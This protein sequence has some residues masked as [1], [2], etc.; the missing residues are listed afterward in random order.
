V[1]LAA[2]LLRDLATGTTGVALLWP[3]T[4]RP[5]SIR[6]RTYVALLV[7]LAGYAAGGEPPAPA[8]KPAP[9]E[10]LHGHPT[11]GPAAGEGLAAP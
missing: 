4:R 10:G 11:P 7:C 5:F 1:G 3:L 2:H 9:E 8:A 6:Y